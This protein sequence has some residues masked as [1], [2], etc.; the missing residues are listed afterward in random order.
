M[1]ADRGGEG[2]VVELVG[3]CFFLFSSPLPH[4]ELGILAKNQKTYFCELKNLG[5]EK[6]ISILDHN[7][8][9]EI[10]LVLVLHWGY[11]D[12]RAANQLGQL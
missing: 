6:N 2:A 7:K 11:A 3:R 10:C 5:G 9:G 12:R 4:L 8:D 1:R